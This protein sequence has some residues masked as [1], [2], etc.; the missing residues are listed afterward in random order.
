MEH[1][2]AV[3]EREQGH[4]VIII[5]LTEYLHSFQ[6]EFTWIVPRGIR[7]PSGHQRSLRG[8]KHL[9][10]INM[11]VFVMGFYVFPPEAGFQ[12]LRREAPIVLRA[13]TVV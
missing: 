1:Y 10:G 13:T 7:S 8:I 12:G 2:K 11:R 4:D 6:G 5:L 9:S 3:E